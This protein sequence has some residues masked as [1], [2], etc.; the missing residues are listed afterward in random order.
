MK[1]GEVIREA[2]LVPVEHVLTKTIDTYRRLAIAFQDIA[3]YESNLTRAKREV[4]SYRKDLAELKRWYAKYLSNEDYVGSDP[5]SLWD[6]PEN[7][8]ERKKA[9]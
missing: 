5:T 7:A 3:M 1:T 2:E 8:T 9:V 4:Q 6:F